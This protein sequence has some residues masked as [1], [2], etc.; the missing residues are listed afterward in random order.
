MVTAAVCQPL[1]AKPCKQGSRRRL[2]VQ[3]E[4]LRVELGSEGFDLG[5]VDR[6]GATGKTLAD[7]QVVEVE[8]I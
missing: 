3:V 4:G 8:L 2:L 5:G 6:V 1:A 7:L